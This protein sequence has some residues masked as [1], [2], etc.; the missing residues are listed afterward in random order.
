MGLTLSN[1]HTLWFC[2]IELSELL[3][4]WGSLTKSFCKDAKGWVVEWK[5]K[6]RGE[7][8]DWNILGRGKRFKMLR[9]GFRKKYLS[10][11]V[12]PREGYV[13]CINKHT[14]RHHNEWESMRKG[15][16]RLQLTTA[17]YNKRKELQSDTDKVL[18]INWEFLKDFQMRTG[19]ENETENLNLFWEWLQEGIARFQTTTKEY[20]YNGIK[21]IKSVRIA[22]TKKVKK[23][24]NPNREKKIGNLT[25]HK[26]R[27]LSPQLIRVRSGRAV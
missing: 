4:C 17:M 14:V 23:R 20:C 27:Y 3:T 16:T 10:F 11:F 6:W 24:G 7:K 15:F 2:L 21:L 19:I 12:L 9:S 25:S 18:W 26:F 13:R 5:K 8:T 1:S 22:T